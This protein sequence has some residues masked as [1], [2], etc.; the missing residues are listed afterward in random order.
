MPTT[1]VLTKTILCT[2]QPDFTML[3]YNV[4]MPAWFSLQ[5]STLPLTVALE[6]G[7]VWTFI[8]TGVET[9]HGQVQSLFY[10]K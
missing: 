2:K 9:V 6:W 4:K 1:P 3:F 10:I 8:S 7:F 5:H